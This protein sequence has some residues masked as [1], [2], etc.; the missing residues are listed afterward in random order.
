MQ[1]QID[2]V[3]QV[4]MNG[5]PL[6]FHRDPRN[7]P[8]EGQSTAQREG[9]RI[10][11]IVRYEPG[12]GITGPNHRI[13]GNN[14]ASS[15]AR[16]G[17]LRRRDWIPYLFV[18]GQSVVRPA[19]RSPRSGYCSARGPL[20]SPS[21]CFASPG[22]DFNRSSRA[23]SRS[24]LNCSSRGCSPVEVGSRPTNWKI[25]RRK[26]LPLFPRL[27][28]SLAKSFHRLAAIIKVEARR[29]PR[30]KYVDE[31]RQFIVFSTQCSFYR[32][33]RQKKTGIPLW[34]P[35]FVGGREMR[36]RAAACQKQSRR[37]APWQ[38]D[39]P[40]GARRGRKKL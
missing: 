31:K 32:L 17:S 33:Y 26:S 39:F 35:H 6:A 8:C 40:D 28:Y 5:H 11:A 30:E 14:R 37:H 36:P 1:E 19:G 18:D 24:P 16:A 13:V 12:S 21:D 34:A 23:A 4:S 9:M 27:T 38:K 15:P 3:T 10:A 22:A 7:T 25:F 20:S 29:S 2:V